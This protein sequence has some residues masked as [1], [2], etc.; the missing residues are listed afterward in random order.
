M[1]KNKLSVLFFIVFFLLIFNINFNVNAQ[2]D[3]LYGSQST[4]YNNLRVVKQGEVILIDDYDS[5]D[6]VLY[7]E[8]YSPITYDNIDESTLNTKNKC[9]KYYLIGRDSSNSTLNKGFLRIY[10]DPWEGE[11]IGNTQSSHYI[12]VCTYISSTLRTFYIEIFR[13][14]VDNEY[15]YDFTF[16]EINGIASFPEFQ[17]NDYMLNFFIANFENENLNSLNEVTELVDFRFYPDLKSNQSV[18]I[19][20]NVPAS[21]YF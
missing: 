4:D 9:E 10:V 17:F 15:E 11:Y 3:C 1:K 5:C 7:E 8:V 12:R 21:Y 14:L 18:Y 20:K 2:S 6:V 16:T 13:E 19:N